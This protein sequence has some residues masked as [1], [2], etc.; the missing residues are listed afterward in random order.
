MH[1]A[2]WE[3][4]SPPP[5][6]RDSALPLRMLETHTSSL[7][8]CVP[9]A[10]G[11]GPSDIKET[12]FS[13]S[14]IESLRSVIESLRLV[15]PRDLTLWSLPPVLQARTSIGQ[16]VLGVHPACLPRS[17]LR[18][19]GGTRGAQPQDL[20]HRVNPLQAFL[21]LR[22]CPPPAAS[23]P[24][25][26]AHLWA[27]DTCASLPTL[28]R[29]FR[30]GFS[31]A[32]G[33]WGAA[34]GGGAGKGGRG[35]GGVGAGWVGRAPGGC[36][37]AATPQLVA[38]DP[39]PPARPGDGGEEIRLDTHTRTQLGTSPGGS[40]RRGAP[41]AGRRPWQR[42]QRGAGSPHGVAPAAPRP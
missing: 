25:A 8:T 37:L 41:G 23:R 20:R 7:D 30:C 10:P 17:W 3:P 21:R 39:V 31:A 27:E 6:P 42:P 28:L 40:C 5:D 4:P 14:E 18:R 33:S 35:R 13:S 12:G 19:Q 36:G 15:C 34:A 11:L 29:L 26:C 9:Q 24:C 2:V 1:T 16:I 32:F 38:G 22:A